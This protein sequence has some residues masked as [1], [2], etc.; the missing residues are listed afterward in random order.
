MKKGGK[1]ALI[2]GGIT[3]AFVVLS[4]TI[5]SIAYSKATELYEE[6]L[7]ASNTSEFDSI[8]VGNEF[9][10]VHTSEEQTIIYEVLKLSGK[11]KSSK[12]IVCES[13]TITN[14]QIIGPNKIIYESENNIYL[15]FDNNEIQSFAGEKAKG[16]ICNDKLYVFWLEGS[17]LKAKSGSEAFSFEIVYTGVEDYSLSYFEGILYL[18]YVKNG[19]IFLRTESGGVF[20][21][22]KECIAGFQPHLLK[23]GSQSYLYYLD[24]NN[25]LKCLFGENENFILT[26]EL[27]ANNIE[28]II[29][30]ENAIIWLEQEL[31]FCQYVTEEGFGKVTVI[32]QG[33]T[34]DCYNFNKITVVIFSRAGDYFII[35]ADFPKEYKEGTIPSLD[36]NQVENDPAINFFESTDYINSYYD[37][38][39]N[40]KSEGKVSNYIE[41]H[42]VESLLFLFTGVFI[43]A[44]AIV[45][46]LTFRKKKVKKEGKS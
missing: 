5:F 30:S 28:K 11:V 2:C 26:K 46:F 8:V 40:F 33:N 34:I 43:V 23:V 45:S 1:F 13:P 32:A 36:L 25:Y 44:I 41:E 22:E 3:I 17:K 18:T 37:N 39:L 10:N 7:F 21:L 38:L 19:V 27:S 6:R 16:I 42:T 14:L 29:N 12:A 20:S 31:I 9:H 15:V 4:L 24:S 35:F